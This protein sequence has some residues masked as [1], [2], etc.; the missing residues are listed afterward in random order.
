MRI[1]A[2]V[3]AATAASGVALQ[4]WLTLERTL[5]RGGDIGL[6][7]WRFL[8]FFT[9][10][11][12]LTVAVVAMSMAAKPT[13]RLADP[14][15]RLA[16][17]TAIALTGIVYSVA[18]RHTW[19][20]TGLNAFADHLLHDVTPPL[21]LLTWLLADHGRL[22]WRDGLWGLLAPVAFFAY[23]MARGATD[24]WYPY[25]FLDPIHLGS[26]R[27]SISAVVLFGGFWLGALALVAVDRWLARRPRTS[28]PDG[29]IVPQPRG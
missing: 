26:T 5:A 3:T 7:T 14:R 25:W 17:A 13:S 1:A 6:S 22:R 10:L 12:N 9:I 27:L 20:L 19:K 15:V 2:L 29:R 28:D 11:A 23:A 24:G 4:Y 16:T 18:L 21:F 8:G